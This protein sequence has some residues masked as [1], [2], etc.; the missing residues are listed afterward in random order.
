MTCISGDY[1]LAMI[2][3]VCLSVVTTVVVIH[4]SA[5]SETV[6]QWVHFIFL[7]CLARLTCMY[8]PEFE[9]PTPA[10]E[11]WSAKK[12]AFK[13]LGGNGDE[14]LENK[15]SDHNPNGGFSMPSS[16]VADIHFLRTSVEEKNAEDLLVQQWKHVGK[17]IDR[18]L[19]WVFSL[20]A[21]LTTVILICRAR[22]PE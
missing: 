12:C 9:H 6:P 15:D 19:L 10:E 14:K 16:V 20:Y 18:C 2:T 13:L 11:K 1:F 22:G 17:V 5:R 7:R 3:M 21:L 8:E 4:V